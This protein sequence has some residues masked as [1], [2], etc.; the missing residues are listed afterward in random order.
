MVTL[1]RRFEPVL[2][3]SVMKVSQVD[4]PTNDK[5]VILTLKGTQHHSK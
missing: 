4:V 5:D 1:G 3:V 2:W